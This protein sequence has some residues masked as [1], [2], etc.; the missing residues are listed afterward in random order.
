MN[1]TIWKT[2][3]LCSWTG[4]VWALE[5]NS[6]RIRPCLLARM[7]PKMTAKKYMEN[8]Q[9]KQKIKIYIQED[10]MRNFILLQLP[11]TWDH[12]NSFIH[13]W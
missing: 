9:H 13:N 3:V 6:N 2:N 5:K 7:F 12:I 4:T 8:I 1:K 10:G 11:M